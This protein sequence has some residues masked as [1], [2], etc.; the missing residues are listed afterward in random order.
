M[1]RRPQPCDCLSH[2]LSNTN[3]IAMIIRKVIKHGSS[4]A[5]V[6]PAPWCRQLDLVRGTYVYLEVGSVGEILIAKLP[7]ERVEALKQIQ[8][9]EE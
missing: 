9:D 3:N 4:L 8:L 6:I 1:R 5:V 2:F 7:P